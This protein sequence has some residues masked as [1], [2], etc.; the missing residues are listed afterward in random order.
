MELRHSMAID[1]GSDIESI[2]DLFG[3][4]DLIASKPPRPSGSAGA[5]GVKANPAF[6]DMFTD[7]PGASR[8]GSSD[9]EMNDSQRDDYID[10]LFGDGGGELS[11][12]VS[13]F[14][15][16]DTPPMDDIDLDSLFES[17][18]KPEPHKR[19][20]RRGKSH[21]PGQ[22]RKP[23][24]EPEPR[25]DGN[26]IDGV[27]QDDL[28]G[29]SG[30]IAGGIARDERDEKPY[31][32]DADGIDGDSGIDGYGDYA[33]TDSDESAVDGAES[34]DGFDDIMAKAYDDS[35][36][37]IDLDGGANRD[38]RADDDGKLDLGD[39]DD[40]DL[41]GMIDGFMTPGSHD[42]RKSNVQGGVAQTDTDSDDDIDDDIDGDDDYEGLE[43]IAGTGGGS[44]EADVKRKPAKALD[45]L[46]GADGGKTGDAADGE[47]GGR[48]RRRAADNRYNG[49]I[50]IASESDIDMPAG[51]ADIAGSAAAGTESSAGGNGRGMSYGGAMAAGNARPTRNEMDERHRMEREERR[52]RKGVASG[53][54]E[55]VDVPQWVVSMRAKIRSNVSHAFLLSGNI[56]D[57]MV[58]NI[59]IE[60][61][62]VLTLDPQL[63]DFDI[64]CTYDQ[65][66]G[67]GFYESD[68]VI[69]DSEPEDYRDAFLAAM[70]DAQDDLGW[71]RTDDVPTNPVDLFT[72]ISK[73]CE[74]QPSDG[75]GGKILMF[76]D[77]LELLVPDA[78]GS[79]MRPD[80]RKLSIIM[81]DMCRSE[82]ADECGSVFVFF[83]D[84][85]TAVSQVIRSTAS[86]TDVI[87]VPAP[88]LAERQDFIDHVIDVD[89]RRLSDGRSLFDADRD[90]DASGEGVTK[91]W[92]AIN[93]AGLACY[94]IEDI[95]LRSLSDDMPITKTLVKE[96]KSDI[97]RT[98][99]ENVLEIMDPRSGFDAIG[100]MDNIKAYFQKNV[101]NPVHRGDF[102][103]VPMGVLLSG[104]PGVG[105][106][107]NNYTPIYRL[108][109]NK[110]ELTSI[111]DL[112]V[113]DKIFGC[114]GQITTV[115]NKYPQGELDAYRI[116]FKDG[117]TG[118]CSA[119][120]LWGVYSR[121]HNGKMKMRVKS[122]QEM[123]D[124]GIF[125]PNSD[126]SHPN[127]SRYFIPMNGPL[128]FP[129]KELPVDPYLL[130][131]FI[132]NGDMA[133]CAL[134]LSCDTDDEETV[135]R[136]A[137]IVH[138]Y[139]YKKKKTGYSWYFYS[140]YNENNRTNPR[141]QTYDIFKD[142][143]DLIEL[144]SGQKYIPEQ[145]IRASYSQRLALLQGLMDTDGCIHSTSGRNAK[146]RYN[147]DYSTTS[148]EL[149]WS[150]S[151]LLFT[152][153]M[154][155]TVC[156]SD[157]TGQT[158]IVNG[159]EYIRKSV[160]FTVRINIPN[161]DKPKLFRLSRK[162]AIAEEAAAH[163]KR[164]N[165]DYVGIIGIEK[166]DKKL[167]MTC[168]TV[169]ADDGLFCVGKDCVVTHNTM[170]AKAVA[171]ESGM[172]CVNLNLNQI[173]DKWVGSSERNLKR[174][175]DCAQAMAPT[176]LFIDEIDEALPN[177]HNNNDASGVNK[178]MN[179]MLL[180]YF[181][182]TT[183][184][185]QV[186]VL[187]ATNYPDKLDPAIKRMG[188]FDDHI[189]MFAPD[190]FGRARIL[191][192]AAK[193]KGYTLSWFESPDKMINNPFSGLINWLEAG[194]RPHNQ[195]FVGN[196]SNYYYTVRID[197]GYGQ[198]HNETHSAYLPEAIQKIIG[199][200]KI[201]VHEFYRGMEILLEG[202]L[203]GRTIDTAQGIRESDADYFAR[204]DQTLAAN[205]SMFFADPGHPTERESKSFK[206]ACRRMKLYDMKY[207]PFYDKTEFMTGAELDVVV[208]KCITLM[209]DMVSDDRDRLNRLIRNK[210]MTDEHD[211]PF[212]ILREACE[213]ILPATVGIKQ[214]EDAALL[215]ATDMSFIP[216]AKY[217]TSDEGKDKSY[218]ER[219]SELRAM[220]QNAEG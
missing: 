170:L 59:S 146:N 89:D 90:D 164:R 211:I 79:A 3:D 134:S 184:R 171:Y 45:P 57:Y 29:D 46:G 185:G 94:Q 48:R 41:D 87:E 103:A 108:N 23:I 197:D 7:T 132:G 192:I 200:P 191:L 212:E 131:V 186:V 30:D 140:D 54:T 88:V 55:D 50:G 12:L 44:V 39:L 121:S 202:V 101:I 10:S 135:K 139:T 161:E 143:P 188:R 61:G 112:R 127:R 168:I 144:Q 129:E 62:I 105:K 151:D 58:R 83:S 173:M 31:R 163:P 175:L 179:Q 32:T 145:Y 92:F 35:D 72:I 183:H 51:I 77:F 18:D 220:M 1:G 81:S 190:R 205:A 33:E 118:I 27:G 74:Q 96:R 8:A 209:R 149:A 102:S 158:H 25:D 69:G 133:D 71:E 76:A 4:D 182:D 14:S 177:R 98:D 181:S 60:D 78:N 2:D 84:N 75:H 36:D 56:R 85:L 169:D 167:P 124:K 201:A 165:Y 126:G 53:E 109:H 208:S 150:L 107:Y 180:T 63:N 17:D 117:R 99:Y 142:L 6:D 100:G 20:R 67:L 189:P 97:I 26:S 49:G 64:V 115:I 160:E 136:I 42:G 34:D 218:R 198:F 154:S 195:K 22:L 111:K 37:D 95:A 5:A 106:S 196:Q 199:K 82:R 155:N 210:E 174:A 68:L 147:C 47:T 176:I 130:G 166:L 203:T 162:K 141:I 153:G 214:M 110:V 123:I 148:E 137:D 21:E 119:D 93:T 86:R 215:D 213:T 70:H 219:L 28:L 194:N 216:D 104:A 11:S 138:A 91:R 206:F 66:H 116:F 24:R 114:D 9:Y 80:E 187:A 207:S 19:T 40:L 16:T 15:K 113:G 178:R 156:S 157:R 120:H 73:I 122:T 204:I 52:S 217:N 128:D 125:C 38:D 152:L 172:N 43:G 193:K 13:D 65:A 159:K